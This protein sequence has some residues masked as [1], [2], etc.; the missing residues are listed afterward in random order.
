M[1]GDAVPPVRRAHTWPAPGGSWSYDTWGGNGRPVILIHSILF[2]RA[3]WWP[4]A[5]E[6]RT[7]CAV[8][9]VD[10]PCHGTAPGRACYD[11]A[12][13]VAE[14]AQL[15]HELGATG[16]GMKPASSRADGRRRALPSLSRAAWGHLAVADGVHR[17]QAE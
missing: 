9:A 14:L 12:V 15:L 5:A 1:T 10:L 7:D 17:G 6:L 13:L 11:P 16:P 3:M 8:I 4:L 2:D